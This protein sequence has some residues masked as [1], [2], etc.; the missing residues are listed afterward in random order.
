MFGKQ[1]HVVK[2]KT[3]WG[4]VTSIIVGVAA[5]LQKDYAHGVPM[6]I[7]GIVTIWGRM[8]ASHD[9]TFGAPGKEG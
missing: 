5:C 1:K 7:S 4:G 8:T 3:I 9:L 2:S 6:I